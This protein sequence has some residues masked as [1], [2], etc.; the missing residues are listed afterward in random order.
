MDGFGQFERELE[1]EMGWGEEWWAKGVAVL[2]KNVI[3]FA[4]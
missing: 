4:V 1:K 3:D 2:S